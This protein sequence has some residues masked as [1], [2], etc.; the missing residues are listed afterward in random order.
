MVNLKNSQYNVEIGSILEGSFSQLLQ[1][2]Y[3]DVRKVI[4]VDE[5]TQKHCLDYV[6]TQFEVLSNAEIIVIPPGETSK[7]MGVCMQVWES[8]SEYKI[9]RNDVIINIG[10][11]MITDLGGFIAAL[12]KRGIDFINVPTS[13][14]AMVDASVGGKTGI[15]LNGYKNQIGC[16]ANPQ[17]IVCD[18]IFLRTLPD[19]EFYAGKAEILKHGLI[20]SKV[21]WDQF[22]EILPENLSEE[23]LFKA[24]AVKNKI[25]L[26]DPKEKG[27][28]KKLNLGHTIG[29]ALEGYFLNT[30]PKP[31]GY[32]VAWGLLT[33][34]DLA[35]KENVLNNKHFYEIE[36]VIKKNYS[37]LKLEEEA[38][39]K[40]YQLM[41][42][43]KKNEGSTINFNLIKGIGDIEINHTFDKNQIFSSLK[44]IF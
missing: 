32:F 20:D 6:I 42:N 25:V 4:I 18:P 12:Y 39:E 33:E 29:H 22:K 16:F 28:R 31:H 26:E 34:A 8:L 27:N 17:L 43:D 44:R 3:A 35:H 41:I 36:Q 5:N 7:E 37:P 1:K 15:D 2:K 13:L 38:Y 9:N 40:I 11:G 21:S 24:V 14:L 30:S 23:L 10:G 19:E